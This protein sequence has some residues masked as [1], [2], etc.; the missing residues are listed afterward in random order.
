MVNDLYA[1]ESESE[2]MQSASKEK[3][4]HVISKKKNLCLKI[5]GV[6][7][8]LVPIERGK[9]VRCMIIWQYQTKQQTMTSSNAN[10]VVSISKALKNVE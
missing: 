1:S 7:V 5:H 4:H 10:V 2:C 9:C 8:P 6:A 3:V